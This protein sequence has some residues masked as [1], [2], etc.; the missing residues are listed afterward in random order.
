MR[1]SLSVRDRGDVRRS[2][3]DS[4][5]FVVPRDRGYSRVSRVSS[6]VT[7]VSKDSNNNSLDYL[8]KSEGELSEEEDED[9]GV[10]S[11]YAGR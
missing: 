8:D 11:R 2:V 6:T 9:S 4:G 10:S 1:D 3:T 5:D 7:R